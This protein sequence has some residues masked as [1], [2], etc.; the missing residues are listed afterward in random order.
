[1]SLPPLP[2]PSFDRPRSSNFL[3]AIQSLQ[4]IYFTAFNVL[5]TGNIDTQRSLFH[6]EAITENA[7]P[8]LLALESVAG[9]EQVPDE[10]IRQCAQMFGTLIAQLYEVEQASTGECAND[11]FISTVFIFN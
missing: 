4:D 8:L 3:N 6:Q 2:P 10:W 7:I 5:S 11:P 1:M 9:D